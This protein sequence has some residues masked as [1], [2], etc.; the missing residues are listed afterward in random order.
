MKT[1]I[2]RL[3]LLVLTITGLIN[4]NQKHSNTVL[5]AKLSQA[6]QQLIQHDEEQANWQQ[7]YELVNENYTEI[8]EAERTRLG[9]VLEKYTDWSTGTLYTSTEP[10]EKIIIKGHI[11]DD[12]KMPVANASLHV[13]QTDSHGYY[14]PSDSIT[15][16][17]GEPF[18][19]LYSFIKTDSAGYFEIRTVRPG[20]YPQLYEG[21]RIPGHVHINITA[22]G[23]A[24]KNLQAVFDDDSVMNA[25]WLDWAKFNK[26]PVLALDHSSPSRIAE[27]EIILN[28]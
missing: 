2:S 23:Y 9:Q 28:K 12:K 27:L 10:G 15:H 17:M 16:K 3:L 26:F 6:E 4:C 13:F 8:S 19:R 18:A 7:L 22:A 11:L 24:A 5:V 1:K 25:F 21:R 14:T 20:S